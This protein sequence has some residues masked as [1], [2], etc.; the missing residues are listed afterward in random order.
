MAA[1]VALAA[2]GD[3]SNTRPEGTSAGYNA[4]LS[5]VVNTSDRTGGTIVFNNNG[6][7]PDSTDPGN[8]YYGYMW[9]VIR[10]Y[11]RA[12]VTYKSAPWAAGMRLVPDL[13]TALVQVSDNGL[14]W[15]YHLKPGIKFEDGTTVTSQDVPARLVL[16]QGARSAG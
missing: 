5:A 11:G 3:G 2:C 15:T 10:L 16:G 4:A 1:A 8:T 14:A 13:A 6:G 7:V 9:N 12:L